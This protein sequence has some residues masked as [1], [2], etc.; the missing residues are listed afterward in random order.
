MF[1][2]EKASRIFPET[3]TADVVPAITARYQLLSAEDQLAL[4]WFAYTEMGRTITVAAL[5]AARMQF[6][7]LALEEISAMS[8]DQQ[9]KVMCDLATK[10]D[11]PIGRQYA[12][13]SI[14]GARLY[15]LGE[16]ARKVMVSSIPQ[17]CLPTPV[18]FLSLKKVE[19]GQQIS[20]LVI[21]CGYG[22][23]PCQGRRQHC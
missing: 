3:Q 1:T 19:K 23:R 13:W 8:A 16:P 20:I 9:S 11:M 21:C 15:E 7:K 17:G 2:V 18:L 10:V 5:G 14:N 4:I 22:V 12:N 6:C